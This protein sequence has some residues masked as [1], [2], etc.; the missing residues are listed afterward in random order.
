M[1]TSLA[2]DILVRLEK[3]TDDFIED[4]GFRQC[5]RE[6]DE[7]WDLV[8]RFCL[9]HK[10]PPSTVFLEKCAKKGNWLSFL[11]HSDVHSFLP[12]EVRIYSVTAHIKVDIETV[13]VMQSY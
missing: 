12:E 3:A 2:K 8:Q 7:A 9:V 13:H 1:D 11:C 4:K 10:L 6:A 5:S